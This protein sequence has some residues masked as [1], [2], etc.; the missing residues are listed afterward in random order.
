[1]HQHSSLRNAHVFREKHMT[2]MTQTTTQVAPCDLTEND[3]RVTRTRPGVETTLSEPSFPSREAI[4]EQLARMWR[5]ILKVDTVEPSSNFFKLGGRSVNVMQL[6]SRVRHSFGVE[7]AVGEV[8]RNPTLA[9]LGLLIVEGRRQSEGQLKKAPVVSNPTDDVA[10]SLSEGLVWAL[11]DSNNRY[12]AF[13]MQMGSYLHSEIDIEALQRSFDE[14]IERHEV[15]RTSFPKED[16]RPVRLVA[17]SL[18][19]PIS[20]VDLTTLDE[21]DRGKRV[22]AH[23]GEVVNAPF[24]LGLGPL[25]R[26]HLYYLAEQRYVLN[27]VVHHIIADA[28]SFAVLRRD[29]AA[30][31]KANCGGELS[32][33][34]EIQ[35]QYSEYARWQRANIQSKEFQESLGYWHDRLGAVENVVR[36]VPDLQE[37]APGEIRQETLSFS[38]DQSLTAALEEFSLASSSTMFTIL[39]SAFMLTLS[40]TGNSED[41]AL[42]VPVAA[43]THSELE[44]V[45]G[46]FSNSIVIHASTKGNPSY[47][48]LLKQVDETCQQAYTHQEVPFFMVRPSLKNAADFS[49][50]IFDYLDGPEYNIPLA[51]VHATPFSLKAQN[52]FETDLIVFIHDQDL[53]FRFSVL[54]DANRFSSGLMANLFDAFRRELEAII[55]PGTKPDPSMG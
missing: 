19:V 8:F 23:A 39:L 29:L 25:L 34:P 5:E 13:N 9:S 21:A 54:F 7:M 35:A 31:Y 55:W 1:M 43:R 20:V 12:R 48:D 4:E 53:G 49:R 11:A 26:I 41:V 46:L 51:N 45:V 33:L 40:R 18:R 15:L 50:V 44:Q 47:R 32:A 14:L 17:G 28:W 16:G 3:E 10:L 42:I 24:D 52:P 38:L 27:V 22:R 30:L 36:L 2:D 6:K 37:S